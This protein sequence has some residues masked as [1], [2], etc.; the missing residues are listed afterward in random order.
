MKNDEAKKKN[1]NNQI[2][3]LKS[4]LKLRELYW[5]ELFIIL[6]IYIRQILDIPKGKMKWN[7]KTTQKKVAYRVDYS[8]TRYNGLRALI[9]F[10][11]TI[12]LRLKCL[13]HVAVTHF[14]GHF[15][16][17]DKMCIIKYFWQISASYCEVYWKIG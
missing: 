13:W 9:C 3:P 4:K 14:V 11:N 17:Y 1:K 15:N 6:I 16:N 10:E 7:K 5:T 12:K 2:N 8:I